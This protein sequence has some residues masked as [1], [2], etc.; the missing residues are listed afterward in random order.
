MKCSNLDE[1]LANPNNYST[2][3]LNFR[4]IEDERAKLIVDALVIN[5]GLYT[6]YLNNNL[7]RNAGVKYIADALKINKNLALIYLSNNEIGCAGAKEIVD[8]LQCNKNL[9]IVDLTHDYAIDERDKEFKLIKSFNTCNSERHEKI[10]T[11]LNKWFDFSDKLQHKIPAWILRYYQS[12]HAILKLDDSQCKKI[13]NYINQ[14]FLYLT[15]ICKENQQL[16]LDTWHDIC[17]YL[18][19]S[20]VKIDSSEIDEDTILLSGELSENDEL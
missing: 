1:F 20:D 4:T 12:N 11:S 14:N 8:V 5:K 16:P 13:D 3:T 2:L 7:I 18:K 6:L 19:I 9:L 10:K 15:L 17:S